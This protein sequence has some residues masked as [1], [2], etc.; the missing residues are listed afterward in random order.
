[1]NDRD[2]RDSAEGPHLADLVDS[3]APGKR[4]LGLKARPLSA[5][6]PGKRA[7]TDGVRGPDAEPGAE[8]GAS[9]SQHGPRIEGAGPE[10]NTAA[11]SVGAK[12]SWGKLGKHVNGLNARVREDIAKAGISPDMAEASFE[13]TRVKRLVGSDTKSD[14]AFVR[15]AD[16]SIQDQPWWDAEKMGALADSRHKLAD[17]GPSKYAHDTAEHAFGPEKVAEHLA[18]FPQAH[19]FIS[20]WA[21]NNIVGRWKTWGQDVNFV[22]P[23]TVGDALFEQAKAGDGIATLEQKLGVKPGGWSD[24]GKT[25]V[26]YRFVVKNPKALAIAMPVG[27]ESGAYQK[28]WVFG[29][30]TLGATA[31]AVVSKLSLDQL[32]QALEEGALEIHKVTFNKEATTQTVVQLKERGAAAPGADIAS[33]ARRGVAGAGGSL[34]Y[35]DKIQASFGSHDVSGVRAHVGGEATTAANAIGA[36]AYATGNAVAFGSAPDLHTAAHE[37]AHVVQQRAGVQVNGGVGA[38]GDQYEQQADAV[39]DAVVA[40]R[41]AEGLL[42]GASSAGGASDDD[43]P[44]Q[45]KAKHGGKHYTTTQGLQRAGFRG[46]MPT[47][48]QLRSPLTYVIRDRH[49]AEADAAERDEVAIDGDAEMAAAAAAEAEAAANDSGALDLPAISAF[50]AADAK[51]EGKTGLLGFYE[52]LPL[53]A[54]LVALATACGVSRAEVTALTMGQVRKKLTGFTGRTVNWE[55][56]ALAMRQAKTG[57]AV[58]NHTADT[59]V[60]YANYA[61]I[62]AGVAASATTGAIGQVAAGVDPISG[63]SRTTGGLQGNVE[64]AGIHSASGWNQGATGVT[65]GIADYGAMVGAPLGI[66]D[67][68]FTTANAID[69][70]EGGTTA[71][72]AEHGATA[73]AGVADMS[74]ASAKTAL[75]AMRL[76][77]AGSHA[78]AAAAVGGGAVVAGAGYL[79]SGTVGV[80]SNLS[81]RAA[82]QD[83]AKEEAGK[84]PVRDQ[85]LGENLGRTA[86]MGADTSTMKATVAGAT[87]V[88]GAMMIAGGVTILALAT[89]PIGWTLLAG[90]ALVGGIAALWKW[91]NK[92]PRREAAVDRELGIDWVP[93]ADKPK[94]AVKAAFVAKGLEP[95]ADDINTRAKLRDHKLQALGFA[96]VAQMYQAILDGAAKRLHSILAAGTA[97]AE[98]ETTKTLVK[99]L[100]LK[101]D[102]KQVP[103]AD[104]I[105]NKLKG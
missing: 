10:H 49:W 44:L 28:E 27:K 61:E 7:S 36:E 2:R 70:M 90:A 42:G 105:A 93:A 26:M 80:A 57:A 89:N 43:A 55:P 14:K 59:S 62:G 56:L 83:I 25:N 104:L 77:G 35:L 87:A 73:V 78:A 81:R 9:D 8:A 32:K 53:A 72:K 47:A 97:H 76:G 29:G 40:G 63:I 19:A 37:A 54:K 52:A 75:A 39:A 34:P 13:Q 88:K 4:P 64:Q 6:W 74:N 31:E 103:A 11:Q 46:G 94:G 65:Q 60:D 20:E 96:N 51:K 30:K 99:N 50:L 22:T 16:G 21:F 69:R 67:G 100:G 82:L 18:Q 84:E 92:G 79:V 95:P 48:A 38:A 41:S 66:I 12:A 85:A 33:T 71:A 5:G 1:M 17:V 86:Q 91:R 102:A 3:L 24:G 98:Y 68:A 15:N 101:V 45:L 23:L 58:K